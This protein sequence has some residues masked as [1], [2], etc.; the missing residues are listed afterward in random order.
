MSGQKARDAVL[1]LAIAGA[2]LL[3]PPVL[4]FFDRPAMLLGVPLI[5]VYVFGVWLALI[6]AAW[7][8]TRRLPQLPPPGPAA[9]REVLRPPPE[10]EAGTAGGGGPGGGGPGPGTG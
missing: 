8:L 5:V 3:L 9:G 4:P 7:A 10:A 1:A 2:L 6:A